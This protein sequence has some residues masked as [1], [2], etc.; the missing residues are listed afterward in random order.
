MLER[1]QLRTGTVSKVTSGVLWES[2]TMAVKAV[3]AAMLERARAI[4]LAAR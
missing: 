1:K 4:R 3:M 2:L